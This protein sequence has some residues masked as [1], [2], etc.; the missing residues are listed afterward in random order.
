MIKGR[1]GELMNT[2]DS[3]NTLVAWDLKDGDLNSNVLL[4]TARCTD[5]TNRTGPNIVRY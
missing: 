3:W 2:F 5:H 1:P 4:D